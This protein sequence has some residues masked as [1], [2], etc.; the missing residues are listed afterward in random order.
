MSKIRKGETTDPATP[1]RDWAELKTPAVHALWQTRFLRLQ[2]F[3]PLIWWDID[4]LVI[5]L[6][7]IILICLT[8]HLDRLRPKDAESASMKNTDTFPTAAVTV[9]VKAR[10]IPPAWSPS[11]NPT[12]R[13]VRSERRPGCWNCLETGHYYTTC[14]KPKQRFC[15][16]CGE[17]G[18]LARSCSGCSGPKPENE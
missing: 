18:Q 12:T 6:L 4:H 2:S 7:D 8:L 9:R 17:P 10:P 3:Q 15:H 14:T 1:S 11:T 5:H 16:A 13:I